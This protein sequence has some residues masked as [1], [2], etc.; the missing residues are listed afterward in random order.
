[1]SPT[2]QVV[3]V[4]GLNTSAELRSPDTSYPPVIKTPIKIKNNS[5][6][7]L[8]VSQG[9]NFNLIPVALLLLQITPAAWSGPQL[10][11]C[12]SLYEQSWIILTV[13]LHDMSF[14][15]KLELI[16]PK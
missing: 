3:P 4:M 8:T 5:V 13:S 1:M 16:F 7:P 6:I 11:I 15:E 12:S 10:S 2:E 14:I 9:A